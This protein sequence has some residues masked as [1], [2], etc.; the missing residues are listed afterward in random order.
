MVEVTTYN[1]QREAIQ[2]QINELQQ[3]LP[4]AKQMHPEVG[5]NLMLAIRHLEDAR[6]RLGKVIQYAGDGVSCYDKQ[7]GNHD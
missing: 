3:D 7:K 6:M 1:Q 4:A 2:N 5:A